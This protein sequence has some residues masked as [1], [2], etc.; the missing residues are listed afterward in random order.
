M[1]TKTWKGAWAGMTAYAVDD[2]VDHLGKFYACIRA[3]KSATTFNA[4]EWV[5]YVPNLVEAQASTS[6]THI[7]TDIE[8]TTQFP[9]VI[10]AIATAITA[11]L[12]STTINLNEIDYTTVK[13]NLEL[14]GYTVATNRTG[15]GT[16]SVTIKPVTISWVQYSVSSLVATSLSSITTASASR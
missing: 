13:Y 8:F 5:V 1:T 16:T 11:G 14:K 2:L 7:K 6:K 10:S 4:V 12:Y 9:A 3:H 15:Y